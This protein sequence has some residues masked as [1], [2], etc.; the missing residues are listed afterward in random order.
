MP[1][2]VA[3]YILF[4]SELHEKLN[5]KAHININLPVV[6][7]WFETWSHT[8]R[9]VRRVTV[10]ENRVLRGILGVTVGRE[11]GEWGKLHNEELNCQYSSTNIFQVI[12]VDKKKIGWAFR[13][14]GEKR[15]LYRV[16]MGK[17]ERGHLGDTGIDG[18]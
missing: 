7:Y 11:T 10:F 17:V 4:S 8:L 9:L 6:F 13:R 18:G 2:F 5:L 14:M 15:V 16:S 12:K 1:L 3:E